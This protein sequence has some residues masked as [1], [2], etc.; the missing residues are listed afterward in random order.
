MAVFPAVVFV[1]RNATGP[2]DA[3]EVCTANGTCPADGPAPPGTICR[4]GLCL[5]PAV[6]KQQSITGLCCPRPV[7]PVFLPL[8]ALLKQRCCCCL[9]F[10]PCCTYPNMDCMVCS[11][12][13]G[14]P[15]RWS[16]SMAYRSIQGLPL[17]TAM[18]LSAGLRL[19]FVTWQKSAR[20][21]GHVHRIP[22]LLQ[23][24]CAGGLPAILPAV[25]AQYST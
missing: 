20:P 18:W 25:I 10:C 15:N 3:V 4:C 14:A 21:M 5:L 2:C 7:L 6:L 9:H 11:L 24:R 23:A 22:L 19:G 1:C 17:L 16:F 13:Q 12:H 8:I